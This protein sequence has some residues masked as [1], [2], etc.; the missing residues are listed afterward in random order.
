M[1]TSP[2]P[3][4]N[5]VPY[6]WTKASENRIM[7]YSDDSPLSDTLSLD[8]LSTVLDSPHIQPPES[9]KAI[10][11]EEEII[12]IAVEFKKKDRHRHLPQ[13]FNKNGQLLLQWRYLTSRIHEARKVKQSIDKQKSIN[14]ERHSN[15]VELKNDSHKSK[16]TNPETSDKVAVVH[17][18]R[19]P[20][21]DTA[22]ISCDQ[23]RDREQKCEGFGDNQLDL[24]CLPCAQ[25][26]ERCSLSSTRKLRQMKSTPKRTRTESQGKNQIQSPRSA[27]THGISQNLKPSAGSARSRRPSRVSTITSPISTAAQP[28]LGM[29]E[30]KLSKVVL[31]S[32][33]PLSDQLSADNVGTTEPEPER[34]R[35][36]Q[37]STK[38]LESEAPENQQRMYS[39]NDDCETLHETVRSYGPDDQSPEDIRCGGETCFKKCFSDSYL[40]KHLGIQLKEAYGIQ[41]GNGVWR[42]PEC[43]YKRELLHSRRPNAAAATFVPSEY[44]ERKLNAD[45]ICSFLHRFS[46]YVLK[47][48][49]TAHKA[50]SLPP[51]MRLKPLLQI[52]CVKE[53]L[54]NE[55][56]TAIHPLVDVLRKILEVPTGILLKDMVIRY[57]LQDLDPA[58]WIRVVLVFLFYQ[59]VFKTESSF[60]DVSVWRKSLA[61]CKHPQGWICFR[62]P[63]T[64]QKALRP[65][66]SRCRSRTF[67]F[68]QWRS[69]QTYIKSV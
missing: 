17:S 4:Q 21:V 54:L 5:E 69:S 29:E 59:F 35:D 36:N 63:L 38:F 37:Q 26:Q 10:P 6:R 19:Q 45:E 34:E 3:A 60:D 46:G 42:C 13:Q 48:I 51:S 40:Q 68:E 41:E 65:L 31:D 33:I 49:S 52:E 25:R 44:G 8:V 66:S 15:E 43:T 57:Q 39:I 1:L 50:A 14:I 12:R 9:S 47:H 56:Y 53:E 23:C 27:F 2:P 7:D 22:G 32:A 18:R 58:V 24:K 20:P 16:A 28:N 55:S 11:S 61:Y 30:S 62:N 64:L 67:E